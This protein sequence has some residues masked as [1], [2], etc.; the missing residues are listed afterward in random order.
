MR[1]FSDGRV[2][3]ASRDHLWTILESGRHNALGQY[4]RI[5]VGRTLDVSGRTGTRETPAFSASLDPALG[6]A[7]AATVAA[8]NGTFVVFHH[9]RS[10]TVGNDGRDIEETFNGGREGLGGGESA[11]GGSVVITFVGTYRPRGRECDYFVHVPETKP[12]VGNRLY[13]DEYEILE[14]KIGP[15]K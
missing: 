1:L 14:G 8:D 5:G 3:V 7:E 6:S 10:I 9:D 15:V 12:R 2:K 4:V 13:K 11:R